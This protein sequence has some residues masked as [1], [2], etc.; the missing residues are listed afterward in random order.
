MGS[1]RGVKIMTFRAWRPRIDRALE[2]NPFVAVGGDDHLRNVPRLRSRDDTA[3]LQGTR[4]LS[5][6][7]SLEDVIAEAAQSAA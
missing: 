1:G 5:D 6:T 4:D 7:D 2:F 3:P